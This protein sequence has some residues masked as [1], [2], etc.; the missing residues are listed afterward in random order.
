MGCEPRATEHQWRPPRVAKQD[1]RGGEPADHTDQAIR[2]EVHRVRQRGAGHPEIEI[3]RDGEVSGE[4][5]VFEMAHPRRP[6]TRLRHAFVQECRRA[7][8]QVVADGRVNR[9]QH[10]QQDEDEASDCQRACECLSV[11][12]GCDQRTHGDREER[13]QDAPEEEH[14]P[15][16]ECMDAISLGQRGEEL[17]LLT[18][19]QAR[20]YTHEPISIPRILFEIALRWIVGI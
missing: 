17:P 1:E 8:A 5:R 6:D 9:A 3:A 4:P 12:H 20:Q 18:L 10:L 14:R 19:A 11:L 13:R 15:P 7:I 2:D 16:C